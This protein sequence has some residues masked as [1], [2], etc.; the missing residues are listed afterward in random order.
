MIQIKQTHLSEIQFYQQLEEQKSKE[1]HV[2]SK[3]LSDKIRGLEEEIRT[4][5]T[6]IS[7]LNKEIETKNK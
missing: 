2:V 4:F 5:K 1:Q 7:E 3:I 6:H